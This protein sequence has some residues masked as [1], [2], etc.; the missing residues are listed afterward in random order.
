MFLK[1]KSGKKI[2]V[3]EV[4]AVIME[5]NGKNSSDSTKSNENDDVDV[6]SDS[7][8]LVKNNS[9]N[10]NNDS[11]KSRTIFSPDNY[12]SG[13][14][15]VANSGFT[16][17]DFR[18]NNPFSFKHFL[19]SDSVGGNSNTLNSNGISSNNNNNNNINHSQSTSSIN[20]NSDTLAVNG[21]GSPAKS[22][23]TSSLSN[24]SMTG[25]RPKIPQF[26]S[27]NVINSVES[28]MKRSPRFS[29]FDSQSSLSDL[30][31]E[32]ST[33]MQSSKSNNSF[34]LDFSYPSSS[35]IN[36]KSSQNVQRSYSHYDM[37]SPVE[38]SS[39]IDRKQYQTRNYA[40]P[41]QPNTNTSSNSTILPDF[42][43]DHLLMEFYNSKE[44]PSKNL[45]PLSA[46]FEHLNEFNLNGDNQEME[47]K[48]SRNFP[49]DLPSQIRQ[50]IRR[51]YPPIPLDLPNIQAGDMMNHQQLNLELP[52]DLTVKNDGID[53]QIY[54]P[55]NEPEITRDQASID[56][57]QSL[58][59]FLS[60]GPIH[61]TGRLADVATVAAND[62][63]QSVIIRLQQEND[64]LRRDLE[65]RNS[66]MLEQN[67]RIS[68]LERQIDNAKDMEVEYNVSLAKS[69]E[70]VEENLNA[71]NVSQNFLITSASQIKF[72]QLVFYS[73]SEGISVILKN[74]K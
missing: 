39:L 49:I 47:Y 22:A 34:N 38:G 12:I 3:L 7:E 61:S 28:K 19:K 46:E 36:P 42:V 43:Q 30:T 20:G 63:S 57:M 52:P 25:A 40:R 72:L 50:N 64:R 6:T 69:M 56:K 74:C 37:E 45:S 5:D 59:D 33:I 60:D 31:D 66:A 24:P 58:P 14:Y 17:L 4:I 35:S 55:H 44:S 18:Q 51:N 8:K 67:R 11:G 65:E 1:F 21:N 2:S 41:G 73:S 13:Q 29:S 48:R 68:E 10:N 27:V 54:G 32:K 70:Q 9:L 23:T 53:G 71:S 26:Q 16:I 62:D 15:K